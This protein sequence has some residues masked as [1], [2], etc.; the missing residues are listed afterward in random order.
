MAAVFGTL[1]VTVVP[2]PGVLAMS[3]LPPTIAFKNSDMTLEDVR[4]AAEIADADGFIMKKRNEYESPVAQ[5]GSN[6]SGGQK[7]RLCIAR[8]VAALL[9]SA[10]FMQPDQIFTDF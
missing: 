6:F 5:G 1:M 7:Q 2:F 3:R 10:V 9:L 4:W 8:A